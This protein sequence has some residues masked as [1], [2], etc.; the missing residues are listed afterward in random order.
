LAAELFP[1]SVALAM[2]IA[3]IVLIGADLLIMELSK[4]A[5]L[6]LQSLTLPKAPKKIRFN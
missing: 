5:F 3:D 1:C 4:L 2:V 6:I